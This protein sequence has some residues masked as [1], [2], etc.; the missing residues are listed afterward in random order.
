MGACASAPS[1]D[2]AGETASRDA[3]ADDAATLVEALATT[4]RALAEHSRAIEADAAATTAARERLRRELEEARDAR[5]TEEE[6]GSARRALEDAREAARETTME[7]ERLEREREEKRRESRALERE[8]EEK[9][10][11]LR[12]LER[13]IER[14]AGVVREKLAQEVARVRRARDAPSEVV[15][16]AETTTQKAEIEAEARRASERALEARFRADLEAAR[17]QY[18]SNLDE[19]RSKLANAATAK[20]DAES[21]AAS[22]R[23][24]C[25][26][27][28]E[29]L[30][31]DRTALLDATSALETRGQLIA[32]LRRRIESL[33]ARESEARMELKLH[34]EKDRKV[35]LDG[36]RQ[37]EFDAPV[38]R[39]EA[40]AV[41]KS[42]VDELA[43]QSQSSSIR[44]AALQ[45]IRRELADLSQ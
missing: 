41:A 11:E 26:A 42:N 10:R 34:V 5:A 44:R 20:D 6:L 45:E 28:D 40:A 9:R 23:R 31:R 13:E 37:R 32:T 24:R 14:A 18:E 35:K 43:P 16:V 27:L 12:A 15:A 36:I 39:V 2:A 33:E 17:S 7:T 22:L 4:R 25:D 3:R 29:R 21:E 19:L 30:A 8:C 1:G 38:P